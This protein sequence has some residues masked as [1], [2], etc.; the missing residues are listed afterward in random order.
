MMERKTERE[1]RERER[2]SRV[3]GTAQEKHIPKVADRKN[4][5]G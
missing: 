4:E 3:Q 5:R 1:R 2:E